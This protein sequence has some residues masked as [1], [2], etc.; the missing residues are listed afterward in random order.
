[1]KNRQF[2]HKPMIAVMTMGAVG[3]VSIYAAWQTQK[4]CPTRCYG[5]LISDRIEA[6]VH[7]PE[8]NTNNTHDIPIGAGRD[9]GWRNWQQ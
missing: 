5:S 4:N 6:L 2:G 7:V 9:V 1:M 8:G 3:T